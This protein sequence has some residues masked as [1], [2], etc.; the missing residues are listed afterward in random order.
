MMGSSQTPVDDQ[1]LAS[2][3]AGTLPAHRR[4]EVASYLAN[5]A[6]A[7]ELLHMAYEAMDASRSMEQPLTVPQPARPM[8]MPKA[9]RAPRLSGLRLHR[10]TRYAVAAVVIFS[11]GLGIRLTV[12]PL[13]GSVPVP[14]L[15]SDAAPAPI[16]LALP[17]SI[18][19]LSFEWSSVP[20]TDHY[21]LVIWDP[22]QALVVARHRADAN[23]VDPAQPFIQSLRPLLEAG[24]PYALRV[25]AINAENRII[26][27][28][29]M[30]EF[31]LMR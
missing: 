18:E 30:V 8:S 17:S 22:A 24:H 31:T 20:E 26:R 27:S 21:N 19:A 6:N 12:G 1:T 10:Y 4:R 9:D 29:G 2:F 11:V 23:R 5:N 7:R 16:D 25:D 14:T 3:M 28:S 13:G 15:R